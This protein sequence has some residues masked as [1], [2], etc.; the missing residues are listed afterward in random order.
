[1]GAVSRR[2]R[3][4]AGNPPAGNSPDDD[5]DDIIRNGFVTVCE[6]RFLPLP[7]LQ[8]EEEVGLVWVCPSGVS[9]PP[10]QGQDE[11]CQVLFASGLVRSCVSPSG[12]V[13]QSDTPQLPSTTYVR[14]SIANVPCREVASFLH[15]S[16]ILPSSFLH[17]PSYTE[18]PFRK[19]CLK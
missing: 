5:D 1:M 17:R 6:A 16:F 2:R 4:T 15:P 8:E 3:Q 7:D 18:V 14:D 11:I 9:A 19:R 10:P 13:V 12:L